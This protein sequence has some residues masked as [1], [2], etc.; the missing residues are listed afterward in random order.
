M[1]VRFECFEQRTVS[2]IL[3]MAP[4]GSRQLSDRWRAA[5][6]AKTTDNRASFTTRLICTPKDTAK[7]VF[8]KLSDRLSEIRSRFYDTP[9][10]A[11]RT[12][13]SRRSFLGGS[14]LNRVRLLAKW[15]GAQGPRYNPREE[16]KNRETLFTTKRY[17]GP[18]ESPDFN[19]INF[20]VFATN[21]LV[22]C[23]AKRTFGDPR[24]LKIVLSR[25]TP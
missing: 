2:W 12:I 8:V 22:R 23:P 25:A 18:R 7:N 20:H 11:R 13:E 1:A 3:P 21:N 17:V 15:N 16:K 10:F 4:E 24:F 9:A 14:S 19:E 5:A 6:N